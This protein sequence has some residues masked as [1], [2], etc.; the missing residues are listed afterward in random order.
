MVI[1][2]SSDLF[3]LPGNRDNMLLKLLRL[4]QVQG[5][6]VDEEPLAALHLGGHRLRNG[7]KVFC[8]SK[9]PD[10]ET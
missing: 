3:S 5:E 8:S 7:L 9:R 1:M 4:L 6:S 2:L 10:T